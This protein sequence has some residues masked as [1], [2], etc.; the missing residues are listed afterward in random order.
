MPH[1]GC[2]QH[3]SNHVRREDQHHSRG[4]QDNL[5]PRSA[6]AAPGVQGQFRLAPVGDPVEGLLDVHAAARGVIQDPALRHPVA[7]GGAFGCV[8]HRG[9]C[10]VIGAGSGVLPGAPVFSGAVAPFPRG[11]EG[12]QDARRRRGFRGHAARGRPWNHLQVR[13]RIRVLLGGVP[14][15]ASESQRPDDLLCRVQRR[16][17]RACFAWGHGLR[18]CCVAVPKSRG[19]DVDFPRLVHVLWV[20][21]GVGGEMECSLR[22]PA[23]ACSCGR[24][25]LPL[26]SV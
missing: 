5:F 17:W 12:G 1:A 23:F 22:G 20:G 13:V 14:V 7:Q 16:R 26:L 11:A 15:P 19:W 25:A 6:V 3:P 2:V 9:Q 4:F 24:Q 8:L 18:H 21:W 10:P